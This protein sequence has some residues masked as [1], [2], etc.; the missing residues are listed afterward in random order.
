MKEN[1][2]G[3]AQSEA[4]ALIDEAKRAHHQ[5]LARTFDANSA[6]GIEFIE[7]LVSEVSP[8]TGT[9]DAVPLNLGKLSAALFDCCD[10]FRSKLRTL[11]L[12]IVD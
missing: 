5:C 6:V 1:D 2:D 7:K 9:S 11:G 8:F 4:S 3:M 12:V 10:A